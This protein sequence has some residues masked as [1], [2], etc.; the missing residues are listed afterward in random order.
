MS[1]RVPYITVS[2][3]ADSPA[4]LAGLVAHLHDVLNPDRVVHSD[5]TAVTLSTEEQP[6]KKKR[7][8]PRKN[9]EPET[10]EDLPTTLPA[11]LPV[12]LPDVAGEDPPDE[13]PAEEVEGAV[14]DLP[15]KEAREQAINKVQA[16]FAVNPGGIDQLNKLT[17]KYGVKKFA[18]VADDKANALLA[19]VLLLVSGGAEV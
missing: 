19:D 16:Y 2:L 14:S 8:R 13:Q 7:G 12:D 4:D 15:P 11:D 10:S 9:P 5:A 1:T 6:P 3:H 17:S 18:D